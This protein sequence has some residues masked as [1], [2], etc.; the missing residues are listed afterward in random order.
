MLR[1]MPIIERT[2][3]Q[4]R[5]QRLHSSTTTHSCIVATVIGKKHLRLYRWPWVAQIHMCCR[6]AT[7]SRECAVKSNGLRTISQN[8]PKSNPRSTMLYCRH[9]CCPDHQ[10]S[11]EYDSKQSLNSNNRPNMLYDEMPLDGEESYSLISPY[12]RVPVRS[13][14]LPRRPRWRQ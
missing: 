6:C 7:R 5:T 12:V 14:V 2:T 4:P 10:S 8:I 9:C 11:D 1:P 13:M 3:S